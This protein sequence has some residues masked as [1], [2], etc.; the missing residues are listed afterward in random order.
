VLPSEYREQDC[1]VP[2]QQ[3]EVERLQPGQYLLRKTLA[4]GEPGLVEWLRTCPESE[5]FRSI[6]SES[7]NNLDKF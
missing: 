5:W 6:P 4:P 2:G 1:I 7:T 3:F